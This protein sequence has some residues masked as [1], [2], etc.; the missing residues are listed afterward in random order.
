MQ[1]KIALVLGATGGIGGEVSRRLKL[2]GWTVRALHRKPEQINRRGE[3]HWLRGDAMVAGDVL[4]AAEGV[5]LVVHAVNPPGYRNWGELVLPML[6]NTLAAARQSGARILLPGTVYNYGP[7]VL[8]LIDEQSLQNPQ[9]RKGKIRVEMETRLQAAAAAGDVKA[10]IVRAGDFF[11]PQAAN[12]WFSQGLVKPG[13]PVRSISYPGRPGVGHQWAYLPDVAETMVRLVEHDG[14]ADFARFHMEGHWDHD[15]R[16]MIDAIAR[17]VSKPDIRVSR[18]PWL[19]LALAS[20]FVPLFRELIEMK[21]LWQ[22]P[23][24]MQNGRLLAAL[25]AEPH[26][27]LDAAVQATLAG[28]GCMDAGE[29][30]QATGQKNVLA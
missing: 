16:Q 21:Y 24:R 3:I 8:P 28:L 18:L 7:D 12:N 25:G 17:V 23:V 10:L 9:T 22:M 20:P 30:R 14:L 19:A 6:D 5:S 4:A 11:G 2:R 1:N 26:T 15:G 13:Q 29:T 27:P